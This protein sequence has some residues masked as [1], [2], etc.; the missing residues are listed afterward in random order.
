MITDTII[1][2]KNNPIVRELLLEAKK[3]FYLFLS[4]NHTLKY[5]KMSD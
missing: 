1:N 4:R 2:K 5:L 3:T